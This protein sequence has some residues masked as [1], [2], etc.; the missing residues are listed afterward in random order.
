MGTDHSSAG[1][2]WG[3]SNHNGEG[4]KQNRSPPVRND[5]GGDEEATGREGGSF[6]G[7]EVGPA[8]TPGNASALWTRV[9][10]RKF[11][12]MH[13]R[14]VPR[15]ATRRRVQQQ[16]PNDALKCGAQIKNPAWP[17]EG[18]LLTDGLGRARLQAD[19]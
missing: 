13:R 6:V 1:P 18:V 14:A 8:G 9:G 2:L 10:I 16:K 11:S 4:S 15:L 17:D 19:E 7:E 5:P 12:R 3:H